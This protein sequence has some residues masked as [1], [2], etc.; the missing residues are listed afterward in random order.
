MKRQKVAFIMLHRCGFTVTWKRT[1]FPDALRKD[2]GVGDDNFKNQFWSLRSAQS[3]RE[4]QK[5]AATTEASERQQHGSSESATRSN[6]Y[7]GIHAT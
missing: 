5:L 3:L 1:P 4:K 7:P 2:A 6:A